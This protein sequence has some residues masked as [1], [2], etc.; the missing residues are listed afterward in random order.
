[1][2]NAIIT[3]KVMPESPDT[4][5]DSVKEKALI[6]CKEEGAKGDMQSTVEPLAFGLKQLMVLGMYEVSDDK[7]F[8]AI[9]GRLAEIEGVANAEVAKMDLAMG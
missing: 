9:A 2:A 7:D 4:D 8:D 1:M 6:I 5:L 3:F